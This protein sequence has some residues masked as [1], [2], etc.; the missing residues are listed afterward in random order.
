MAFITNQ[1]LKDLHRVR[2]HTP[3][4]TEVRWEDITED[5]SRDN[6]IKAAFRLA[7]GGGIYQSVF[8][9]NEDTHFFFPSWRE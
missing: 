5:W 6:G 4:Q 9:T 1:W 2:S 7:K 8:L 3:V